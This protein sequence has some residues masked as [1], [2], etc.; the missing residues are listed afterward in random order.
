MM[1][2]AAVLTGTATIGGVLL[3]IR[4]FRPVPPRPNRKPYRVTVAGRWRSISRR[5]KILLTVGIVAGLLGAAMSGIIVLVVVIPVAVVGLPLLLGKADT[6]ERDLLS[7]LETWARALA[8]TADTGAFTLKEVIGISRTAAPA[9]L[10]IRVDRMYQRMN[11]SWTTAAALRAFAEE[12]D[13]AWADE[14]AIYLIQ[15]AEYH[16][17]GLSA[18]LAGLA[19]NL[20]GQVKA[21]MV[22]YTERDK[23]RRTLVTMTGIIG[24]VL[25]GIVVFSRT[26][27]IAA[28]STPAGQSILT[29]ILAVFLLLLLWAK[30]QT[31]TSAEPRIIATDNIR[32]QG[33]S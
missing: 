30:R 28:Y 1:L 11:A 17:G 27:Q 24:F 4:A 16:A 23:P 26:P 22:I 7:A 29:I 3:L 31:H 21:R 5:T 19:D 33:D 25:A 15:A 14:V 18:A 32:K 12:M 6:R 13:D 10:R 20:A 9:A 2:L 8:A